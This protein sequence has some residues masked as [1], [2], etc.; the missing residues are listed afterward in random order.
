MGSNARCVRKFIYF[1]PTSHNTAPF[2]LIRAAA[3]Y[4]RDASKQEQD[5]GKTPENRVIINVH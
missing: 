2:R 1:L 4:M 5:Q 3:P